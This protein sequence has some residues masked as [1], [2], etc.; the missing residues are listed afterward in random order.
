[1]RLTTV[2]L[3]SLILELPGVSKAAQLDCRFSKD[4][5]VETSGCSVDT[6]TIC[7]QPYVYRNECDGKL[8]DQSR[9]ETFLL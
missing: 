3:A 2:F 5:T 9:F 7:L 1:M 4:S 6:G 8:S